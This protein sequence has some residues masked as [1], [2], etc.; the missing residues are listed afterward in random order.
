MIAVVPAGDL[1]DESL[2]AFGVTHGR[3][4]D[5]STLAT[6]VE[7]RV[8]A[9]STFAQGYLFLGFLLLALLKLFHRL[10]HRSEKISE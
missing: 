7:H 3:R 5:T 10:C 2:N 9:S 4:G 8:K 1:L 6:V